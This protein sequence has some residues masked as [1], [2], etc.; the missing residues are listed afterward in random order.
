MKKEEKD[1][2]GERMSKAGKPDRCSFSPISWPPPDS[3]DCRNQGMYKTFAGAGELT[4]YMTAT[5]W[6]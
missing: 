3:K 6:G 2:S 4:E 1:E 5:Y